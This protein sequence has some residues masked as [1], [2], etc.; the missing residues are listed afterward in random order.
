MIRPDTI[1][2]LI[3]WELTWRPA[4]AARSMLF[5]P[6]V[7]LSDSHPKQGDGA[8]QFRRGANETAGNGDEARMKHDEARMKQGCG[9]NATRRG[10]NETGVRRECNAEEARMERVKLFKPVI[11][12]LRTGFELYKPHRFRR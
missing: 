2:C 10:A 4:I 11:K 7:K 8:S 6:L 12:T 3:W 9:A 1:G 5:L